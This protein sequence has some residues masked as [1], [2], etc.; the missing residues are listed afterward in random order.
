MEQREALF[1][2][3]EGPIS[4]DQEEVRLEPQFGARLH[5]HSTAFQEGTKCQSKVP[6]RSGEVFEVCTAGERNQFEYVFP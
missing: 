2:W 1:A 3:S 6:G 5:L 4:A